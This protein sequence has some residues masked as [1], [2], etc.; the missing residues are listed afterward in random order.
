MSLMAV[1]LVDLDIS[2]LH[3]RGSTDL[4]SVYS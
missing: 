3:G 4:M 1:N 2:E